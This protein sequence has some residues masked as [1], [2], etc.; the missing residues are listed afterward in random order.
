MPGRR[1]HL[2]VEYLLARR[3]HDL[4]AARA[5]V[6]GPESTVGHRDPGRRLHGAPAHANRPAVGKAYLKPIARTH[7]N[8]GAILRVG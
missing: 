5:G 7:I 6:V 3:I 4:S 2:H 1:G 8:G